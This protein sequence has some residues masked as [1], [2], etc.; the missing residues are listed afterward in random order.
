MKIGMGQMLVVCGAI[1]SN[2]NRAAQMIRKAAKNGCDLVI[3]P[4]CLDIGW[5][6]AAYLSEAEG[7]PGSVLQYLCDEARH[8]SIWVAA[9][10]TECCKDGYHNASVLI[11]GE[12]QLAGT[13]RKINLV[14]G[15]ETM[16][17]PGSRVEVFDTPWGKAGITIC[18]DNLMEYV[19]LGESL[20]RMGAKWIFSPCAWAVSDERYGKKYGDEWLKPYSHLSANYGLNII[21][22]SNVGIIGDGLWKDYRCIGNSIAVVNKGQTVKVLDYGEDAWMLGILEC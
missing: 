9:G 19:C 17:T 4:E 8:S 7:F 3:L 18:A 5:A 16:Y 20:A 6:N 1:N 12:G 22:V 14:D 11:S 15:V 10:I 13:H 21:G 2:L